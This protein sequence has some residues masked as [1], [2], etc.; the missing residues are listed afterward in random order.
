[1]LEGKQPIILICCMTDLSLIL[2]VT[3][4][5]SVI[6]VISFFPCTARFW[7]YLPAK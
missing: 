2:D 5:Y 7:N 1:M 6:S 4:M 3:R